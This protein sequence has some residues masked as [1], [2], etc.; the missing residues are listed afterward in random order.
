MGRGL[1]MTRK[2]W[3]VVGVVFVALL[4]LTGCA[5]WENY[6]PSAADLTRIVQEIPAGPTRDMIQATAVARYVEAEML[7][8]QAAQARGTAE[9]AELEHQRRVAAMT[10]EAQAQE[11]ARAS[12]AEATRQALDAQARQNEIN[13]TATAQ[14]AA[15]YAQATQQAAAG[16]ATATAQVA[17]ANATATA[18]AIQATATQEARIA[19]ATAQAERA[20]ATARA[21]TEGATATT[22]SGRATA[23]VQ[24]Q[25][26]AAQATVV[27]ATAQAVARMDRR[28]ALLEPVRAVGVILLILA[29]VFAVG[30]LGL[31]AWTLLEDRARLVRRRPDEGEPIMILDRERVA[32]PLRQ[33]GAYA[34]MT[35]G[36]ER[37]PMLAP[38]AEAQERATARQQTANLEHAHQTSDVIRARRQPKERT[39][40]VI[41][42]GGIP[43]PPPR[44]RNAK[45]SGLLGVQQLGDLRAAAAAGLIAPQLAD[46][47]EGQWEEL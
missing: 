19:T 5:E 30:W 23:T 21:W 40:T 9:A 36:Q 27:Q 10:A 38:S 8:Q 12:A 45:E 46:S 25:R 11:R 37:A 13:A 1:V 44:R 26:D 15:A 35:Y 31:Q 41:F 2:H 22:Q 42:P 18:Q 33:W 24:T 43:L 7:R 3:L 28:E 4:I 34:D 32:L 6:T 16:Q 39:K 17:H 20:T 47:I 29:A 14:A